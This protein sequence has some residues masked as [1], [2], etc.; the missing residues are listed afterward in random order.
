MVRR[1]PRRH[2]IAFRMRFGLD[3]GKPATFPE[4]GAELGVSAPRARQL[5]TKAIVLMAREWSLSER[6][7]PSSRSAS[8]TMIELVAEH[9]RIQHEARERREA[10]MDKRF[11]KPTLATLLKMLRQVLLERTREGRP[12]PRTEIEGAIMWSLAKKGRELHPFVV[13]RAF[14]HAVDAGR[15]VRIGPKRW[16]WHDPS[17]VPDAD[18]AAVAAMRLPPDPTAAHA[19]T[20]PDQDGFA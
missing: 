3:G 12:T 7:R 20:P 2:A 19:R 10:I 17:T 14:D 15:I 9:A 6:H 18:A 4:I 1:L 13:D 16:L 5:A 11:W 8:R